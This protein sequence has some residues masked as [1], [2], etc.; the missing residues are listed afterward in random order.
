MPGKEV[1]RVYSTSVPL[2]QV[3]AEYPEAEHI[4]PV[5]GKLSPAGFYEQVLGNVPKGF[6]VLVEEELA[7]AVQ[8][9]LLSS[10]LAE[11]VVVAAYRNRGIQC[12]LALPSEVDLLQALELFD[13]E[14]LPS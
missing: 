10:D 13:L 9:G 4:E 8:M 12:L 5:E 2:A 7:L 6:V 1:D 3:Q 14:D 11:E